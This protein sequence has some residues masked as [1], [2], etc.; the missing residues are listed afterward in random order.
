M[1]TKTIKIYKFH[2]QSGFH[3]DSQAYAYENSRWMIPSDTLFSAICHTYNLLYGKKALE[4]LINHGNPGISLS[5]CFPFKGSQYFFPVPM[6]DRN[7]PDLGDPALHKKLAKATLMPMESFAED[8]RGKLDLKHWAISLE[9]HSGLYQEVERPRVTIDRITQR[10]NIFHFAET[11]Y[12]EEAGL[13]FMVDYE[14]K[15]LEEKVKAALRLLGDEGIGSD[16]TVGKGQFVLKEDSLSLEMPDPGEHYVSL[17]L[18]NPSAQEIVNLDASRS[19][20]K[21][22]VRGGWISAGGRNLRRRSVRMLTEGSV[23]CYKGGKP[24]EG[25]V[26]IVLE[27]DYGLGHPVYRY[28]KAFCLPIIP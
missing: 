25:N 12:K 13:Y 20:Y 19:H 5:S 1:A 3:L 23:I 10:T 21:M 7:L 26:P 24:P 2:F 9:S 14:E 4:A 22:I 28:G 11:Q 8:L 15:T 17:S 27:D 18:Y 16:S 6:K